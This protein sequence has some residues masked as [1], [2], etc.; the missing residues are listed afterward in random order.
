MLCLSHLVNVTDTFMYTYISDLVS[1]FVSRMSCRWKAECSQS[2]HTV[3]FYCRNTYW[4][5]IFQNTV[6]CFTVVIP[7]P[8]EFLT[9]Y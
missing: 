5:T 9:T 2:H 3:E 4:I 1:L 6:T 8:C 7:T